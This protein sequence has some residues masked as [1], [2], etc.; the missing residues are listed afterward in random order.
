MRFCASHTFPSRAA[1]P[2]GELKKL[3][4]LHSYNGKSRTRGSASLRES[5]NELSSTI[6][7]LIQQLPDNPCNLFNLSPLS[8]SAPRAVAVESNGASRAAQGSIRSARAC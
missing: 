5:F 7:D 6:H 3:R 8:S 4:R 2:A 1:V